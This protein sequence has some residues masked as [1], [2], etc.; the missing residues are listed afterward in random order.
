MTG[1]EDLGFAYECK[2]R[3]EAA[4]DFYKGL[5]EVLE[6]VRIIDPSKAFIIRVDGRAFHTFTRDMAKPYSQL[7]RDCRDAASKAVMT[8]LKADIAYH[9]SD[10]ISFVWFPKY[11][12][13]AGMFS[14][15]PFG[16]RVTKLLTLTASLTTAAFLEY[17]V[18]HKDPNGINLP[19]FDARLVAATDNSSVIMGNLMWREND[20]M[21]NSL[22]MLASNHFSSDALHG[23]SSAGR[24]DKLKEIGIDWNTIFP[25]YKRGTYLRRVVVEVELDDAIL[26][27]IPEDRRPDPG[28]KFKRS[29]FEE[30]YFEDWNRSTRLETLCPT[31]SQHLLK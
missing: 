27:K 8:S 31:K 21:R 14:E 9:Q 18:R 25:A 22:S 5:E 11:N 2:V 20:A 13:D 30:V 28:T 15:H 6:D 23:V 17:Y 1:Y 10:E 4:G 16:G 3:E 7:L 12:E 26:M 29:A 19:H 24:Y